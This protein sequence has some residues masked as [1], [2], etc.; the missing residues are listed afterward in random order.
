MQ[1]SADLHFPEVVSV[2][3]LGTRQMGNATIACVDQL[4]TLAQGQA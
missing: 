4:E 1:T 2:G 3:L